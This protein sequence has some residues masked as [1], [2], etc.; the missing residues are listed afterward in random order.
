MNLFVALSIFRMVVLPVQFEDR[1]LQTSRAQQQLMLQQAQ[2][3]FDRQFASTGQTF[4]FELGP[5]VTLG[6]PVAWYG[7]NHPDRKDFRLAEAVREACLAANDK[8]NFSSFDSDDDGMVDNVVLLFP[9]PGEHSSDEENDIYPQQG[10]LSADDA[11]LALDGHI[12][13]RYAVAPEGETGV[14]CHEFGHVLGL[15]DLYDTD[16]AESGGCTRELWGMSLMDL[17]CR[18]ADFP[19]FGALEYELLGLG[20]CEKL[21]TGSYTLRPLAAGQRYLRAEADVEDEYFLFEARAGGLYVYHIDRSDNPAGYSARQQAELTARER[22]EAGEINNN[23]AHPCARLIPA[24]PA[25]TDASGLPFGVDGATSFGSDTP[26]AFRSWSGASTGFALTGIRPAA[27]GAVT[28]D[29][30]YP[31]FLGE[32]VVHQ[33]A[34]LLSWTVDPALDDIQSYVVSW[35]DGGYTGRAELSADATT[36]TV[37]HLQPKT[38]YSYSV[39]ARCA[40]SGNF[41]ADGHFTTK[42][43]RKGTYPYIFLT[44]ATRNLDGSFPAGSKIPLRV[45]NAPG[46]LRVHWTLDGGPIAPDADG[47]YTV[48]K[49]G[50]LRALIE[51][52]DGTSETLLKEIKVQ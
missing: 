32:P 30:I 12:I 38:D 43:I 19:D 48:R 33:D 1:E 40:A 51:Y 13:D 37:E 46:A 21:R 8:V 36:C 20:S 15:P 50:T 42:V 45:Y 9:G 6:H 41:S 10:L 22:W 28:F 31:I 14:F 25:A 2:T 34:A 24:D 5:T 49:S 29:V 35:T 4:R 7:A 3:Y 47:Y 44:G 16:G 39:Q 11:A 27:D 23:P 18:E 17:G 52:A 26:A